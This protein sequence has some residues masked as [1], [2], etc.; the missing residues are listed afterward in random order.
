[1]PTLKCPL[2]PKLPES[3]EKLPALTR[4]AGEIE[5]P[6]DHVQITIINPWTGEPVEVITLSVCV[7]R[8]DGK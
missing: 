4:L 7:G 3:P 1:M 6:E 2:D 8:A 5:D